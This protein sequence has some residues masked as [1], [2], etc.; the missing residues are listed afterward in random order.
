[1]SRF[2]SG[3]DRFGSSYLIDTDREILILDECDHIPSPEPSTTCA[4]LVDHR[5]KSD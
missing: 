1:M 2:F 4:T 3:Y 5:R